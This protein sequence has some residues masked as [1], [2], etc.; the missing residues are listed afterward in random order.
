[1]APKP[2]HHHV[3]IHDIVLEVDG[4]RF[5]ITNHPHGALVLRTPDD[6]EHPLWENRVGDAVDYWVSN[7]GVKAL[8][9]LYGN[10]IVWSHAISQWYQR[11]RRR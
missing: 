1:M 11:Q 8:T 2:P 9:V 7:I 10:V 3:T 5:V 6:N 4:V